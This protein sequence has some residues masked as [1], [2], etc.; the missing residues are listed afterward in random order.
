MTAEEFKALEDFFVQAGKQAV[1]IYLNQ[2]TEITDYEHFLQS[3][4]IPLR[5]N[6][7]A[8]VNQPLIYRL[9]TLKLIIEANK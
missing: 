6:L 5:T 9:Q 1:P 3:H 2:A 8:R 7:H 4:L